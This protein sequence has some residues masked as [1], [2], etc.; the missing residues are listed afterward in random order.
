MAMALKRRIGFWL[1][2]LYGVGVMVGA[3]IYVLVGVV[4]E[5]AGGWAPLAFLIAGLVAVP[6]ALSYSEL[7]TR[8]PES[9]GEAAWVARATGS[10]RLAALV[11][12]AIATV[13]IVSS[14]AILQGGV[15]YLGSVIGG[16]AWILTVAMLAVL[17][18]AATLG[19]LESLALAGLLTLVELAGLGLVAIVGLAAAPAMAPPPGLPGAGVL[20]ATLLAFFAYL[21]FEDMVNMA[22]EVREPERVMPRAIL[23]AL[24]LTA[25]AY[26]LVAWAAVRAVPMADL[27]GSERPLALVMEAGWPAAAPALSLIAVAAAL[28]GVLAQI[29]MSARI[30]YG[31]GA[32]HGGPRVFA[33]V[34]PRLGTPVPA[35]LAVAAAV[36]VLS[37]GLP[38]SGLASASAALLL[39][40]FVAMNAAL[41][42]LRRREPRPPGAFAAPRWAPWAGVILSLAA[43]V[44]GVA[45]G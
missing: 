8:I 34:H 16:D 13:G 39:A 9:A 38:L 14:A 7:V 27:A 10:R 18:A 11:G 40:V 26:V 37:L 28:N 12:G 43:L 32:R 35:T 24:A 41:I 6:T 33:W 42:V 17:T 29:V 44:F 31:L 36:L 23:A 20:A 21:G 30:L 25:A 22:E 4:A 19:V 2:T 3:G 5:T 45:T 1:L 15:G